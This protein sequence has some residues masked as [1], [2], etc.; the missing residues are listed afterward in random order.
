MDCIRELGISVAKI[1]DLARHTVA[2]RCLQPQPVDESAERQKGK[3]GQKLLQSQ[4]QTDAQKLFC[5]GG[6][7]LKSERWI[8]KGSSF[9]SSI[10]I[11]QITLTACAATVAMAAPATSR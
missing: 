5:T 3:L 8:L 1:N 9:F 11:A 10:A 6:F 7:S 4:R 2:G